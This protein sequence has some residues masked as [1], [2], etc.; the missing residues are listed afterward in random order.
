MQSVGV[1]I[2]YQRPKDIAPWSVE[3][4]IEVARNTALPGNASLCAILG[5]VY[6]PDGNPVDVYAKTF[7]LRVREA[8]LEAVLDEYLRQAAAESMRRRNL[9]KYNALPERTAALT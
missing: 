3:G 2:Q 8:M 5:M 9:A 1:T 4:F 7:S 6:N